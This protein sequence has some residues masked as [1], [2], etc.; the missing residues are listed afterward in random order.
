MLFLEQEQMKLIIYTLDFIKFRRNGSERDIDEK[1][2]YSSG[3]K[4]VDTIVAEEK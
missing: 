4:I 3:V 2:K 1:K